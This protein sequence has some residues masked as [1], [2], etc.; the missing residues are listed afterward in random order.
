MKSKENDTRFQKYLPKECPIFGLQFVPPRLSYVSTSFA[1]LKMCVCQVLLQNSFCSV[2]KD[3]SNKQYSSLTA[4]N[5][6]GFR[7][8]CIQLHPPSCPAEEKHLPYIILPT[9][10]FTREMVENLRSAVLIVYRF[11]HVC[12]VEIAAFWWVYSDYR[13]T[14]LLQVFHPLVCG[15]IEIMNHTHISLLFV[16]NVFSWK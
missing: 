11:S 10:C 15:W 7:L 5:L 3:V 1:Y 6:F 14:A 16:L 13:S 12:R 2:G 9:P 8:P 4:Y